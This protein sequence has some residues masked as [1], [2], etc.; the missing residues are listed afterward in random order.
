MDGGR[1]QQPNGHTRQTTGQVRS[2]QARPGERNAHWPPTSAVPCRSPELG[3]LL[4]TLQGQSG[5]L[6]ATAGPFLSNHEAWNGARRKVTFLR[7]APL[8]LCLLLQ[9]PNRQRR[10]L[11]QN[12]TNERST[13]TV[14][15]MPCH[16]MLFATPE[17]GPLLRLLPRF[18]SNAMQIIYCRDAPPRPPTVC[19]SN[20]QS[21][22]PPDRSATG[23]SHVGAKLGTMGIGRLLIAPT[24]I[25]VRRQ[26]IAD[27]FLPASQLTLKLGRF[28]S[29][30]PVWG[31][32]K[33]PGSTAA[34]L[35]VAGLGHFGNATLAVH[36]GSE[37]CSGHSRWP[38]MKLKST[39]SRKLE[40]RTSSSSR[41]R[42]ENRHHSRASAIRPVFPHC[43]CQGRSA[44]HTGNE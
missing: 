9:K 17:T 13:A 39:L 18:Q 32:R 15:F 44:W 29:T 19:T 3:S 11:Q 25:V 24:Y 1:A 40:G 35:A 30:R 41:S 8:F 5:Q 2:G 20:E 26:L 31:G 28:A 16:A 7:G 6:L 4:A 21:K 10:L 27:V 36:S 22:R 43:P 12:P 38:I 37:I 23:R 34:M 42:C 33:Y 14:P